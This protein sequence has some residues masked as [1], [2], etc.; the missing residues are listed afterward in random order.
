MVSA[1]TPTVSTRYLLIASIL[2]L[3]Y[4]QITSNLTSQA[5]TMERNGI[6]NGRWC[7]DCVKASSER[8]TMTNYD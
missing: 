4:N 1:Y 5:A 3:Q 7:L 2:I 6:P 8:A